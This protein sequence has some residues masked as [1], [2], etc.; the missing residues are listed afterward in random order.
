M[1]EMGLDVTL[2]GRKKNNSIP[3][4]PQIFTV[5]RLRLLFEKGP[6]FYLL[7][8]A[9]IF[10]VLLFS[11][12]DGIYANDLD[13]LLPA[14]LVSKIK[15]IPIIYD[16]HE[17][18][19]EVPELTNRPFKK[20][21]W[22]WIEKRIFKR[23]STIITVNQSIADHYKNLY[24]KELHVIRNISSH[25]PNYEL[26]EKNKN[27]ETFTL[28]IQGSGL[29][30]DRGIEEAVQAMK[31]IRNA[32]LLLVGDGDVLPKVKSIVE[33][34]KLVDKVH[35]IGRLPYHEMMRYTQ[36]SDLGLSLDK[37][38]SKNYT[39]SLPNKVFDYIHAN[40]PIIASNLPEIKRIVDRYNCGVLIDEVTPQA[41]ALHVNAVLSNP[42]QLQSLKDNCSEASK[43]ENW[44][45][46][47]EKLKTIIS[48]GFNLKH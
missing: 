26:I 2:I 46:E 11:K 25:I 29:N 3:V 23:L 36:T 22:T 13:T 30:V 35:L 10:L 40:T 7:L 43:H 9:R 17:I 1:S 4:P 44:E 16:S 20:G 19:T 6:L 24:G 41:I 8:N 37:P 33:K 32:Q 12:V 18:F 27:P 31:E 42:N 5:K 21:I 28:I 45:K 34:E 47:A 14:F 39:F 48:Q 38:T 15:R